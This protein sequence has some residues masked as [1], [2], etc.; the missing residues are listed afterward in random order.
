MV[1]SKLS[2]A[3]DGVRCRGEKLT[4]KRTIWILWFAMNNGLST[5]DNLSKRGWNLP[6]RCCL[7]CRDMESRD[8]L[9]FECDISSQVRSSV[10][11]SLGIRRLHMNIHQTVAWFQKNI[12]EKN[13]LQKAKRAA[14]A[15]AVYELW[16]ERNCRIFREKARPMGEVVKRVQVNV[17]SRFYTD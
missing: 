2:D 10:L 8:H 4:G 12:K 5:I 16:W 6:N 13:R 14:L 15:A 1:F 7:C 3:Y 9:F 11:K 17:V